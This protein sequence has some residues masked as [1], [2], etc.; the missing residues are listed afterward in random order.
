MRTLQ[1]RKGF[2]VQYK[3]AGGKW[4]TFILKSVPNREF[5]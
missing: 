1:T 2:G 5:V 4:G 3:A